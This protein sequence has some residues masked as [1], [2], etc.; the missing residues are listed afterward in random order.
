M[1]YIVVVVQAEGIPISPYSVRRALENTSI[2][3]GSLPE[4]KL[5]TGQGLM[6]VDKLGFIIWHLFLLAARIYLDLV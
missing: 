3:V 5:S 6:Q 2:P 4:D 1:A